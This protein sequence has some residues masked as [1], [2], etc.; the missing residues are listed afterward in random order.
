MQSPRG[1][2]PSK[3]MRM[4]FRM[5]FDSMTM[6]RPIKARIRVF[7]PFWTLPGSPEEKM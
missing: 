3:A 1:R 7:L 6:A 2:L 4:A 5:T